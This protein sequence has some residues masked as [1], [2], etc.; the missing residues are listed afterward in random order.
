MF[1]TWWKAGERGAEPFDAVI[2]PIRD[3]RGSLVA[4]QARAVADDEKRTKGEKSQGVFF[5]TPGRSPRLAITEAPM[6]ALVLAACG[7]PAIAISGTTRPEWLP[8]ALTGRNVAL[9]TDA[10]EAGDKCAR[11]LG[12]MLCA[13]RLRPE[14]AKDWAELAES[15]GLGAVRRQIEAAEIELAEAAWGN[16]A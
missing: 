10:D 1:G 5:T 9:A 14:G 7:L 3:A 15:R 12:A 6:N 8:G 11:E 4:A 16:A 13:W 2:F